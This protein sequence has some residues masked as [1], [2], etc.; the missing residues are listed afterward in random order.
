MDMEQQE[1]KNVI[2]QI[3]NIR[4]NVDKHIGEN[5]C[6]EIACDKLGLPHFLPSVEVVIDDNATK[7]EIKKQIIEFLE[8]KY[9]AE[10][11]DV[12]ILCRFLIRR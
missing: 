10:V 2:C 7:M 12:E 1:M 6:Y 3:E 8:G 11:I 9:H 4:W 5:E